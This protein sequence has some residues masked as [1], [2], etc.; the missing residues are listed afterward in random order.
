MARLNAAWLDFSERG[1]AWDHFWQDAAAS[2]GGG[3]TGTGALVA[4]SASASGAGVSA[5]TGT[6]ALAAQSSAASGSGKSASTGTGALAVQSSAASGSGS[7]GSVITGTGDLA[8]QPSALAASGTS[9]SDAVG[10]LAAASSSIA[11][12]GLVFDAG[13]IVGTGSLVATPATIAGLGQASGAESEVRPD[14][15]GGGGRRKSWRPAI[16]PATTVPAIVGIGNLVAGPAAMRGSGSVHGLSG[17]E[18]RRRRANAL[19]MA[20]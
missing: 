16:V 13:A 8:G 5:S 19:L 20:A 17:A 3:I 14:S 10:A 7:V 4:Q 12:D 18:R 15:G 2:G 9:G 6:G 11:G 1:Q